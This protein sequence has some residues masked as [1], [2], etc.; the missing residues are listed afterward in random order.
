MATGL[1]NIVTIANPVLSPAPGPAPVP[2]TPDHY[3]ATTP[4][5]SGAGQRLLI[6]AHRRD[7]QRTGQVE[8]ANSC[9]YG[10]DPGRTA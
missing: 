9:R 1:R 8:A 2:V 4:S 3:Q 7:P 6:A 5:S 10:A